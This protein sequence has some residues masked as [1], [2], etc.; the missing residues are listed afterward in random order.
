MASGA[1]AGG[2]KV[3]AILALGA[4]SGALLAFGGNAAQAQN[5]FPG[6]AVFSGYSNGSNV[7]VDAINGGATGP[8]VADVET[9]FS[10]SAATYNLALRAR[11]SPRNMRK[12]EVA[13]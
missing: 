7:H 1:R 4:L 10:G 2:R 3:R 11:S 6:P 8:R 5:E 9:T 13:R 12:Q